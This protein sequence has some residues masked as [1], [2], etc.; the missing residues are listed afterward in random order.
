VGG[1][2]AFT[3][4]AVLA[5]R[6]PTPDPSPPRAMRVEGGEFMTSYIAKRRALHNQNEV[7]QYPLDCDPRRLK[8][9]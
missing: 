2:A 1:S 3:E 8:S 6:P 4:A 9:M 5:D 7:F